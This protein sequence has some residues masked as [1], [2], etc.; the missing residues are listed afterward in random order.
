MR[1]LHLSS[2]DSVGGAARSAMNLHLGLL[3]NNVDSVFFA[4]EK[5]N[6]T[7]KSVISFKYGYFKRRILTIIDDVL[8]WPYRNRSKDYP[9]TNNW[10]PFTGLISEIRKLKPDVVHI[11]W[12][13]K[14]MIRLE[15]LIRINLPVVWTMHDSYVYTGGCHLPNE[16]TNYLVQ[17]NKC[18]QLQSKKS[19][20]LSTSNFKRKNKIYSKLNITFLAPSTWMAAVASGSAL[21]KGLRVNHLPNTF[22]SLEF[23][24]LDKKFAKAGIGV[25]VN[26]KLVLF[27]ALNSTGDINKGFSELIGALKLLENKNTELCVFGAE[28]LQQHTDIKFKIHYMGYLNDSLSKRLLYSAAD[29]VVVPSRIENL[30]NVIMESMAC[31]TPVAAFDTGGNKDMIDHEVNGF[32]AAKND[33]RDL[34]N[35]ITWILNHPKIE[36]LT[37]LARKKVVENYGLDIIVRK[38][39]EIYKSVVGER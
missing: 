16:C 22:N 18:P 20:D 38:H 3:N 30:S 35:G 14:G 29:V 39:L 34:A 5:L 37:S 33:I 7:N 26:V 19:S 23:F 17:C 6:K 31:G 15:D 4:A 36:E 32:L 8:S 28:E 24:P 2:S 21:L 25:D 1:I 10:F 12:V 13:G 9:F 11:H 27:G